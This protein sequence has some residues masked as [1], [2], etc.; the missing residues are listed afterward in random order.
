MEK[1]SKNNKIHQQDLNY[2]RDTW[3]AQPK[4]VI[5]N[6]TQVILV[7]KKKKIIPAPSLPEKKQ[8][9]EMMRQEN[10]GNS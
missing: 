6:K 1:N 3:N 5:A 9:K 7:K 8:Y 4:N 2:D 10:Y